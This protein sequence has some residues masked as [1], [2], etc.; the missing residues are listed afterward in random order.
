MS[1][2]LSLE[3]LIMDNEFSSKAIDS[4]IKPKELSVID[5]VDAIVI[6]LY[7]II[8]WSSQIRL[9]I[10]NLTGYTA[11]SQFLQQLT[12]IAFHHSSLV[13][14]DILLPND[15]HLGEAVYVDTGLEH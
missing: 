3:K 13:E 15:L 8:C 9:H 6:S 14:I 12:W 5:P 7:I 2:N 11:P 4:E 10:R 1:T